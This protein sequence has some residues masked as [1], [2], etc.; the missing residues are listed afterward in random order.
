M[1][2]FDPTVSLPPLPEHRRLFT[3][4]SWDTMVTAV[5]HTK[6]TGIPYELELET[7]V[8]D[9]KFGCIWTRFEAVRGPNGNI[10]GLW[11]VAQDITER[12][13]A[14]GELL[15][16]SNHDH[17]TGL[18]NRRYFEKKLR[19]LDTRKDLPLSIIMCDVN[20]L[21][22]I[23]D[24]FGHDSGDALLMCAAKTLKGACREHDVIAR[25]GGDEFVIILPRTVWDETE[26]IT[27]DMKEL[28]SK[29]FV[30]NIE[31]SISFG[32]DTKT[33]ESQSITAVVANAENHMYTQ[34]LYERS[35]I[36]SKTIDLIMDTLFEKSKREAMHSSRVSNIC[37]T[38]ASKMNFKKDAVNQ[39]RI[40]G[41]IHDIGKIGVDEN[42]LNKP[43]RL[44]PEE[45]KVIEGHPEIGWKILSSTTEFLK[46]SQFVL[47]HH[48]N[49]DGS[50]YPNG[51]KGEE[52][53]LEARIIS[54]AD[55]YD[56]MT[57]ERSYRKGMTRE[58]AIEELRR[59]SG[60]QFDPKIVDVFA[61]TVLPET[62]DYSQVAPHFLH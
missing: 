59:C 26:Q 15:Y 11:G 6:T 24:S 31:L 58:A 53:Q 10:T 52:I 41:L 40:A 60:T 33:M 14:E 50:G 7:V 44:T 57:S 5:E 46:L 35:S 21:K 47:S 23:N 42:I 49:W 22:L 2:G 61:D 13:K 30:S 56:A 34:K 32:Y 4:E 18:H 19:M 37:Q 43:G 45:R 62:S 48:E 12:K 29:E 39:M 38:I 54:V 17:L 16:Q 36:R 9:G 27:S 8:A 51:L 20:G 3:E 28:A 1:Y 25:I 55:S